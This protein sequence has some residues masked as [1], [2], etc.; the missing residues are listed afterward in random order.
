[1]RYYM[2]KGFLLL[3]I[4]FVSV[5]SAHAQNEPL[6]MLRI[7]GEPEFLSGEIIADRDENRDVNGNLTAGIKIT[8]DLSGLQFRSNNGILKIVDLSD[9]YFLF[10]STIERVITVYKDGFPPFD[11]VLS[12]HGIELEEGQVW[13]LKLTGE[14]QVSTGV[15]VRFM[16]EPQNSTLI[17]D[18]KKYQVE[19]ESLD[20]ELSEGTHKIQIYKSRYEVITDQIS[21][22]PDQVNAF[23]Y[24]LAETDP[25]QVVINSKPEGAN[26][27]LND[28]IGSRGVTPLRINMYPGPVKVELKLEG[29]KALEDEFIYTGDIGD[30]HYALQKEEQ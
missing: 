16:V 20:M 4:L 1:M 30:L 3:T 10:V 19:G 21:I 14:Q 11:I 17:V 12:D 25:I 29:Y 8:S 27:Y 6:N 23:R 15:P 22:S 7:V 13:G 28:S 26:V 2:L 24:E 5:G 9:S 18:G